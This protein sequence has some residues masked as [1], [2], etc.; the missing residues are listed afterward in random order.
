MSTTH[1][2]HALAEEFPDKVEAIHALKATDGP[3]RELLKQNRAL[4]DQIQQIQKGIAPAQDAVL[5]DLEKRRLMLLDEIA[6][7]L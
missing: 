6:A 4:W 2:D 3:F 5:E 7:R 1:L